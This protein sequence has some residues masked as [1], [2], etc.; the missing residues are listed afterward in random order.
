MFSL[1]PAAAEHQ[2][3]R[4]EHRALP[5]VTARCGSSK[6]TSIV[7][8]SGPGVIV[9]PA[10]ACLFRIL[11]SARTGAAGGAIEIQFTSSPASSPE[12]EHRCADHHTARRWFGRDDVQRL[13]RRYFQ[14]SALATVK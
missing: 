5:G 8:G 4:V 12:A 3:A 1:D 7:S 9:A 6:R 10:A 2:F 14:T 13:A 11:I